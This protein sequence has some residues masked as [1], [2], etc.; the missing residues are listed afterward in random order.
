MESSADQLIHVL[1]DEVIDQ[2]AAGEVVERPASVVKELVE[3][4]IDS[5]AKRVQVTIEGGGLK[6]ISVSDDGR[7]MSPADARLSLMRHATS[8]LARAQDLA[9]IRTLGF[10]G[11]ALSSIAAVSRLTLTTRRQQDAAGTRLVLEAGEVREQGEVG[12]PFGTSIDV[13]DLFF[14]TP[15]RRSFMRSPAT[16]QAHV[17]EAALRAVLGSRRGGLTVETAGRRLLDVSEEL[18]EVDRAREALGH[19]VDRLYPLVSE[20]EG[21][22]VS[23]FIA[24]PDVDRA[25]ARGLWFFVNGRFVRDRMLQ[26]ALLDGYRTM[27]ARGRFPIAL[28]HVDVSPTAVDVNVHPQKLEVR[29]REA[30][31]VFR[32]VSRALAT[33]L[34]ATP[35]LSS[36]AGD[37][38]PATVERF[39]L[40]ARQVL[41]A[42]RARAEASFAA[43]NR[44]APEPLASWD[45]PNAG[46]RGYFAALRP[47]GQILGL[48]LVCEG[49]GELVL[50][51]QHA[52]HER[53]V[54]ERLRRQACEHGIER[55]PLLFPTILEVPARFRPVI[56]EHGDLLSRYGFEVELVGPGRFAVRAIPAA[57]S[58]ADAET[59][60][61]DLFDEIESVQATGLG[62]TAGDAQARVLSRCACHAAV[63]AG[64]ALGAEE[65]RTLLLALDA[66]DFGAACPHG[67]PVY[68]G[69]S[70]EEIEKLFR[71]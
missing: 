13:C 15:A 47:V 55:Q 36:E 2:I 52:A 10:R 63:R 19:R 16:E 38:V 18:A 45:R 62:A 43:E 22:R 30:D 71:R 6:S 49:Q 21:V 17:V 68:H 12:V 56:E 59:L 31:T 50:I 20:H 11:E 28:V 66:V 39:E 69:V 25:D 58:G 26:R 41:Y 24:R 48:F 27:V 37:C 23:G 65:I 53:V 54:F 7:G 34:A 32:S 51:D 8:K 57:L 44:A 46:S 29:F 4:A 1:A 9:A 33:V 64:D 61:L 70:R 60:L 14:N 3:N 67:R 40:P 42:A 35:W 5:G